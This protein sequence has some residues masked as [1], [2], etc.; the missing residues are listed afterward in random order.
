MC[1]EA[2]PPTGPND[3]HFTSSA[4]LILFNRL[5]SIVVGISIIFLKSRGSPTFANGVPSPSSFAARIRPS[6]P[7]FACAVSFEV[8]RGSAHLLAQLCCSGCLQLSLHDVPVR[9]AQIRV[10][11]SSSLLEEENL[12]S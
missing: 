7:I 10:L 9:G 1:A 12:K 2:T 4:L 8:R 3:E 11:V 6:S 5:F